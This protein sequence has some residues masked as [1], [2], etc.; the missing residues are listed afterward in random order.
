MRDD[1]VYVVDVLAPASG[2]LSSQDSHEPICVLDVA[3]YL[4]AHTQDNLIYVVLES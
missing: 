2:G 4:Y 1:Q 3:E